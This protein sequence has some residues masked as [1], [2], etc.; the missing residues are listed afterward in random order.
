MNVTELRIGNYIDIGGSNEKFAR[1]SFVNNQ[2]LRDV[3]PIT[4]T[5]QWLIDFGL[6]TD[7]HFHNAV[8]SGAISVKFNE[9]LK[10][11]ELFIGRISI[12]TFKYVH[13]LQNLYFAL[14]GTE[15]TKN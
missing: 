4:L 11:Y 14:T 13:T 10:V 3:K 2:I 7:N 15:L 12:R 1:H 5:E 6:N 9:I 8:F